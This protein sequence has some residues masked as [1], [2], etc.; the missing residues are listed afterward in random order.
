MTLGESNTPARRGG[1]SLIGS[2]SAA[3]DAVTQDS[4][5]VELLNELYRRMERIQPTVI[6]FVSVGIFS[7]YIYIHFLL[8]AQWPMFMPAK[9][10]V[11]M[12]ILRGTHPMK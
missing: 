11:I 2:S 7:T 6:K 8:V 4:K 5:D 9:P 12:S 3:D 10:E 1:A